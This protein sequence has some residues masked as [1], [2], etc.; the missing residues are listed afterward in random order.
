ITGSRLDP[1]EFENERGVILEDLEKADDDP[2]DVASERFFEAVFGE[3]PLG[4]PIGGNKET[5]SAVTR[6]SVWQHYRA[7]Y[8]PHDLVITVAGAVDHDSL[9]ADVVRTLTAGG[10]DLSTTSSP[11]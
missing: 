6:D 11:V 10:W 8:R 9:V 7:N 1:V 5:I 2:G 4:R 3:H